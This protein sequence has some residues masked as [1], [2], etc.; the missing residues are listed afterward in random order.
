MKIVIVG[1]GKVGV[2]LTALLS[3]EGHDVTV[4]DT[5]PK[6]I[7]TVVNSHDVIGYCGNG[8]SFPVQEEAG[9]A[10][11]DVFIAVTGS[12]ELNIM[13]CMVAEK[14]GAKRLV[15]RVRNTD[16]SNQLMFMQNKLGID[17]IINPELET[18][19]EISR[20]IAFPAATAIET[21]AK[22]RI[23]LAGILVAEDSP[24]NGMLLRDIR[25][26]LDASMLV[27]VVQRGEEVI[28][29]S[30]NFRIEAGDKVHFTAAKKDIQKV[31]RALGIQKKKIKSALVIG[32]SRTSYYLARILKKS[33]IEIKIIENDR[34]RAVELESLL[35]GV[36]VICGDGTD[37][38][39]LKEEGLENFDATVAL[40]DIDEENIIF[41][42][43]AK[44]QGVKKTVCKV[45]RG[46]LSEMVSSMMKECSFVCPKTNTAAIILRYIR[47]LDNAGGS[48]M[49]TLYK[50][51]DGRAEAI[52]F[53]AA[54]NCPLNG[55]PL[56]EL[57]LK[58]NII[59]ACVSQGGKVLIPDGNTAIN[60]GDSVIVITADR[61]I[62]DLAEILR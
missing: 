8:A 53:I 48:E 29:P 2:T 56:K 24:L 54:E 14:I 47:A 32:G 33:G 57:S 18:A 15:A 16:Y 23:D 52:E 44:T 27:C 59:I 10:R 21:F 43:Y 31:F 36:S 9:V 37:T 28:I 49:Q 6:L 22:G 13:S 45:N 1:G 7:E 39:L 55:V 20:I 41:S 60:A 4:I 42:M 30:G 40:T 5:A 51:I 11:C 34:Q 61:T 58:E 46:P 62:Y 19:A 26:E 35:D 12:D 17:L 3:G 25:K 38:D 50:I